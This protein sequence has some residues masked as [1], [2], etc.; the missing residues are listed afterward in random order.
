MSVYGSQCV[1]ESIIEEK[2]VIT[3]YIDNSFLESVMNETAIQLKEKINVL[4][5]FSEY[6]DFSSVVESIMQSDI[7]VP[8][9]I[10]LMKETIDN[11][12]LTSSMNESDNILD[13]SVLLE[14]S[15]NDAKNK[16]FIAILNELEELLSAYIKTLEKLDESMTKLEGLQ[17]AIIKKPASFKDNL[18]KARNIIEE[19]NDFHKNLFKKLN[20]KVTWNGFISKSKK[21]NNKYSEITMEEKKKLHAKL[22]TY[23]EKIINLMDPW[24]K[25]GKE[26]NKVTDNFDKM[27]VIDK[28]YY[29]SFFNIFCSFYNTAFKEAQYTL[30]DIY[31]AM[32]ILNIEREKSLMYKIIQAVFKK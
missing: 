9:K 1:N 29:N 27:K 17:E 28:D 2:S 19:F 5:E 10:L 18:E 7:P 30:N 12:F 13:E 14:Y 24:S 31:Y 16:E 15:G 8:S 20:G 3:D 23:I 6:E 26:V 21:F 11:V 32:K 22:K 25:G 4:S